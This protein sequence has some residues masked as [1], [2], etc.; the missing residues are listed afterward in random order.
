MATAQRK[1]SKRWARQSSRCEEGGW[2]GPVF[3][4]GRERGKPGCG[5][6]FF[7]RIAGPTVTYPFLPARDLVTIRPSPGNEILQALKDSCFSGKEWALR[8]DAIHSRSKTF[9]WSC[10]PASPAGQGR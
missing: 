10:D 6:L 4:P 3:L 9:A 2:E 1:T 8:E 5:R 7:A